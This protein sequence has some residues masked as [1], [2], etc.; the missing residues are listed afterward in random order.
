MPHVNLE[1]N[2][3]PAF[4]LRRYGW[5]GNTPVSILTDFEEFCVYDCR[6]QPDKNDA[7]DKARLLY[8]QYGD[9]IDKWDE[10][11][12]RFSREAVASGSLRE[13]VEGE[14]VRGVSSVDQAFLREMESWR[15]ILAREIALH[16][17]E[18][19]QRDL[20]LLVQRTI[21]RIVFLRIAEDRDIE[22]YGRLRSAAAEGKQV[23]AELKILFNEA[24][25]KY[26]SGLFHFGKE[27]RAS[28]PD[29][30]SL[31]MHIPDEPLRR[32]IKKLYFPFSP[33]EFSV[34]PADI[35]GPGLRAIPR[36]SHRAQRGRRRARA[37]KAR[38][39]QSRRRLL[40]ASLHR[41]LHRGKY[42]RQAAGRGDAR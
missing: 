40:H 36:Q 17:R 41:R 29:R 3:I 28:E 32:I 30:D 21:D 10:L 13:W 23:Y 18:L 4:Q 6:I 33:Y 7:A 22:A 27:K 37:R 16:N 14:R 20:N 11:Q 1:R 31:N 2:P 24:D 5:S 39:A 42:G 26:N 35:L 34:L 25:D 15:E 9:Y 12:A 38:S 8:F 19:S